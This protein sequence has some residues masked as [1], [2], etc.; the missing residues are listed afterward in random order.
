MPYIGTSAWISQHLFR[1]KLKNAV[2]ESNPG[3]A[4]APIVVRGTRTH[5]AGLPLE[6]VHGILK[7]AACLGRGEPPAEY[8]LEL[9]AGHSR[10]ARL[11]RPRTSERH[12]LCEPPVPRIVPIAGRWSAEGI[13]IVLAVGI[14]GGFANLALRR[15]PAIAA[16][17]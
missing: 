3:E 11:T 12:R 15:R 14:V 16:R 8:R 17:T 4:P 13:W 6:T 10:C 7:I 9:D 1:Q 5:C 2:R